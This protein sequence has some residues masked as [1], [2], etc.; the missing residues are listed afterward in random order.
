MKTRRLQMLR[1]SVNFRRKVPSPVPCQLMHPFIAQLRQRLT[2]G[3]LPGQA[4]QE[5]MAAIGREERQ[6]RFRLKPG[7]QP[8]KAGVLVLFFPQED[9][10]ALPLIRR[11]DYE[12]VHSRQMAFPGGMYEPD[13]D[14]SL[15]DT[16]LRETREEIGVQV[17]PD[18]V[19]GQLTELYVGPSNVLVTPV[20]AYL[21]QAPQ[22]TPDPH[23]VDAVF[24]ITL[25]ELLNP[26]HRSVK[27]IRVAE[28]ISIRAPY[29]GV[30]Q[31]TI[32]G[33]TAMMLSELL[34]LVAQIDPSG[35]RH[36]QN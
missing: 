4:A 13:Q 10:F 1:F 16:A 18:C 11:P 26:L 7:Q 19:L 9:H 20:V 12:G 28:G 2:T 8:R 25:P 17:S 30:Q 27:N 34:A 3:P 32:W 14:Q 24:D 6:R 31:Q 33:A 21:D 23:E 29:F 36:G 35:Q 5:L 22:Y 15:Q